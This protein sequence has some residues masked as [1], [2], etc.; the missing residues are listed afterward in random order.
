MFRRFTLGIT[1]KQA[2]KATSSWAALAVLSC[3]LRESHD[4]IAM[5]AG[6]SPLSNTPAPIAIARPAS[7]CFAYDDGHLLWKG[8]AGP[9]KVGRPCWEVNALA[10]ADKM[11]MQTQW[12][13]GQ[14]CRCQL[15]HTKV[16]TKEAIQFRMNGVRCLRAGQGQGWTVWVMGQAAASKV[17]SIFAGASAVYTHAPWVGAL[18]LAEEE[19]AHR[20]IPA[21]VGE[22][23]SGSSRS[24]EACS[25]AAGYT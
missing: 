1:V 20:D 16:N 2:N 8:G 13:A 23:R 6:V 14:P 11:T 18:P 10:I 9:G 15:T 24:R 5:P 19:P 7:C 17:L 12:P 21:L 3:R 22:R 25:S 4:A